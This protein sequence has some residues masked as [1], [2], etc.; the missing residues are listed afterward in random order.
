MKRGVARD[1]ACQLL[2]TGGA[3]RAPADARAMPDARDDDDAAS[4]VMPAWPRKKF[5]DASQRRADVRRGARAPL[6]AGHD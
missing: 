2:D 3:R 1:T 6:A 4:M 5:P